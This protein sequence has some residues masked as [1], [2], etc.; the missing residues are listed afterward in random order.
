VVVGYLYPSPTKT[1]VGAGCCR[2][3]HRTVR[4]AIGH[5]SM[6]QPR[7]PTIRVLTQSIVGALTSGGAGQSSAAP[8]SHCSLSSVPLTSALTSA[9]NCSPVRGTVQSTVTPKS[10]CSAV[11][12][13]SPVN[14]S[15]AALEKPESCEFGLVWSWCTQ[16]YPVAHR[17]VR[18]AKPGHSQGYC[19]FEIEPYLLFSIG[20]C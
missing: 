11:T 6:C 4:C 18:C 17:T 13:N 16:H 9:A 2:W 3:A 19:S 5:C 12:P 14:Y 8:D 7:H 20:L 1:T 15:G 10:R